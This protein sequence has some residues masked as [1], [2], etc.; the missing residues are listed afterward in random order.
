M[1]N[2]LNM[3][4]PGIKSSNNLSWTSGTSFC[5]VYKVHEHEKHWSSDRLF[6]PISYSIP[7]QIVILF[8]QS[9]HTHI[10]HCGPKFQRPTHL[11]ARRWERLCDGG[12]YRCGMAAWTST[13]LYLSASYISQTIMSWSSPSLLRS[14]CLH[15]C[16]TPHTSPWPPLS[17][18]AHSAKDI[19]S[20]WWRLNMRTRSWDICRLPGRKVAPSKCRGEKISCRVASLW[21]LVRRSWAWCFFGF[22]VPK[23]LCLRGSPYYM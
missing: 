17:P 1:F 6:R 14:D 12:I 20:S 7:N 19:G 2:L 4:S 23:T 9:I 16:H 21:E 5:I 22:R 3:Y 15:C 11:S 8:Q 13:E 10:Y 18:E